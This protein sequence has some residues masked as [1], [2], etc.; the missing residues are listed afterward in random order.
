[1]LCKHTHT[2]ARTHTSHTHAYT[3]TSFDIHTY[4]TF[5]PAQ[6][7]KKQDVPASITLVPIKAQ[8][9]RDTFTSPLLYPAS[10][11]LTS[12]RSLSSDRSRILNVPTFPISTRVEKVPY[13]NLPAKKSH[14]VASFAR[15]AAATFIG[16]K[17][18][19]TIFCLSWACLEPNHVAVI[20]SYD[21]Y[22]PVFTRSRFELSQPSAPSFKTS[23][24]VRRLTLQVFWRRACAIIGTAQGLGCMRLRGLGL[25]YFSSR[26][27]CRTWCSL[28]LL[29]ITYYTFGRASLRCTRGW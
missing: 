6:Q 19:G 16:T 23:P 28:Q 1:M 27:L 5:H 24:F 8:N 29:L 20:L 17:P 22:L 4:R 18:L 10:K 11:A 12:S 7:A 9:S 21:T 25:L 2:H 26:T 3:H 15:Y 13:P 14:A